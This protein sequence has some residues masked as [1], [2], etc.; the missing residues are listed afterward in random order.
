MNEAPEGFNLPERL[1][2]ML[3]VLIE[4]DVLVADYTVSLRGAEQ[5]TQTSRPAS[6]WCAS[7]RCTPYHQP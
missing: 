1:I 5:F 7:F 2:L 3:Y 6:L 4:A